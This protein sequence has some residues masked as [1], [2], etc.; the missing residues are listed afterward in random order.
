MLYR[1]AVLGL[2]SSTLACGLALVTIAADT[3]KP[4]VALAKKNFTETIP[5]SPVK[6]EMIYVPAGEF[7]MGSPEKEPGRQANEGP[8]HKVAVKGFWIGKTEVSWDEFDLWWKNEK[9]TEF[10]K[11]A[12]YGAADALTRPTNPYVPAD[13]GHGQE[14]HP[15]ICMT[16]HG[17]MM[18]C[19]WLRTVTKKNYRLP[20]EAEWEY[21][22]RA[23]TNTAYSFGDSPKAIGDYA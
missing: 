23:G 17:A 10:P 18:Y 20:T 7:L 9:L 11:D 14:G 15:A 19:H 2:L 16:H 21:A 22:C 8:Q 4:P 6:F 13:Y 3:P 12:P 1:R 5:G